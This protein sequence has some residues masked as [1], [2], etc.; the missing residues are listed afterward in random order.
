MDVN[1]TGWLVAWVMECFEKGYLKAEEIDGLEMTW[2]NFH[3]TKALLQKIARREG[4]GALLAE[5]VKRAAQETGGAALECAVFTEKGNTPRSHDHRAIWTELLDTCV[6]NTGTIECSGGAI[7]LAH[8][9][10]KPMSDPFS[11]EQVARQNAALNGRRVFED[12]LGVCRIT[13]D[14]INLTAA[15]LKAA[16]GDDFSV[17]KAME[18]GKRIVNL[19]RIFNLKNGIT[20]ELDKPSRRYASTPVDGPAKGRSAAQD[21][22]KMKELYYKLMGWDPTT[23]KPFPETLKALDIADVI[24]DL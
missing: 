10:L 8:H 6:S 13:V 4:I 9:N 3:N 2:G 1:E 20:A 11:W 7:N 12:S 24:P 21:F 16:T 15:A 22:D 23:G 14:D 17:E 5:G 18:I 19:M